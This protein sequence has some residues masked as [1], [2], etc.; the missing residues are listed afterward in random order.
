MGFY[1]EMLTLSHQQ[2][3][4][5][6]YDTFVS[7][8]PDTMKT[9]KFDRK[10]PPGSRESNADVEKIRER[11]I[12]RV[13]GRFKKLLEHQK[14]LDKFLEKL[15]KTW[16]EGSRSR[17]YPEWYWNVVY[18]DFKERISSSFLARRSKNGR[19]SED[20]SDSDLVLIDVFTD[21]VHAKNVQIITDA[22]KKFY[23]VRYTI[24]YNWI[25]DAN[26]DISRMNHL[27]DFFYM[28]LDKD[29]TRSPSL[30]PIEANERFVPIQYQRLLAPSVWEQF[31]RLVHEWSSSE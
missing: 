10:K 28:M 31:E 30:Y 23:D 6:T 20:E 8:T 27:A 15:I 17:H 13:E 21:V 25:I 2:Q 16:A 12:P 4:K 19:R 11:S 14:H 18:R 24:L 3:S 26:Q 22:F 1:R 5:P 7:Y 9:I 29:R